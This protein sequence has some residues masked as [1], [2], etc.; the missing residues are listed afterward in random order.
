MRGVW[1]VCVRG[2]VCAQS[3]RAPEERAVRVFPRRGVSARCSLGCGA[4]TCP[5]DPAR[6]R[7]S[8]TRT[9]AGDSEDTESKRHPGQSQTKSVRACVSETERE[10]AK[11]RECEV[12]RQRPMSSPLRRD[13]IA[14]KPL[15]GLLPT[16]CAR[17]EEQSWVSARD[18]G[19]ETSSSP[20]RAPPP[21]GCKA[22]P[23]PR[24]APHPGP[25]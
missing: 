21:T 3:S 10:N 17:K 2:R 13:S 9:P 8:D 12:Q 20:G 22:A 1:S 24:G 25:A 7:P 18:V 19:E 4:T 14:P 5:L 11:Q 23:A 16:A 6:L 15:P